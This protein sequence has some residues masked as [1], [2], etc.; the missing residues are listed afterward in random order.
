[1]ISRS[2]VPQILSGNHEV[3]T[4]FIILCRHYLQNSRADIYM[5]GLKAVVG[6]KAAGTLAPIKTEAANYIVYVLWF[7]VKSKR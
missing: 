3:K 6:K 4:V 2:T 5:D 7:A 1:M